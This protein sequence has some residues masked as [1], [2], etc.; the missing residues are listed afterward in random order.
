MKGAFTGAQ[1]RKPGKFEFANSGTVLLDE[2]SEM[3]PSLQAKLLQVLQDG[4]FTPLG[5]ADEVKVDVRI[6]AATN[7]N[8]ERRVKD[9]RFREDLFYR[10]NVVTIHL[11][12]LCERR[13]EIPQLIDFFLDKYGKQYEKTP[14]HF[15]DSTLRFFNRYHWPGNIRELENICKRYVILGNESAICAGMK[16]PAGDAAGE[17]MAG[18]DGQEAVTPLKEVGREAAQRAEKELIRHVLDRTR[19]NRRETSRI[20]QISYK[21]LLYKIKSSGLDKAKGT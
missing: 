6:I 12:A 7:R 9:G 15:A 2:I 17:M 10:L 11:P 5:G 21:A 1:R 16:M 13:E 4:H 8:L 18:F 20:L 19:W 14:R 3:K